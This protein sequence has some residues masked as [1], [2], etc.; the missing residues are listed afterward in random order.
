MANFRGEG[1]RCYQMHA[2]WW[3]GLAQRLCVLCMCVCGCVDVC[4]VGW[5]TKETGFTRLEAIFP[6]AVLCLV[7]T[8]FFF[9]GSSLGWA[10]C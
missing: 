1:V 8:G 10:S 7:V 2:V 5:Q 6:N 3:L 9:S 4:N